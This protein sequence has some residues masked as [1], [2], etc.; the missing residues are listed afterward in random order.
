MKADGTELRRLA[1]GGA[2]YWGRD[3]DRVFYISRLDK[4]L[5]SISVE[6]THPEPVPVL[7]WSRY[8][9]FVSA[10]NKRLAFRDDN[11][12]KILDMNTQSLLSRWE[13]PY[14]AKIYWWDARTDALILGGDSAGLWVY[15]DRS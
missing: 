6:D 11:I 14:S 4:M 10:D 7:P 8:N 13:I 9:I 5:Y 12:L 15:E 1:R 2:H 3:S